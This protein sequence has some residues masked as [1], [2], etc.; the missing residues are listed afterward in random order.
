MTNASIVASVAT[1]RLA[2]PIPTAKLLTAWEFAK[3]LR[4]P[5]S[6]QAGCAALLEWAGQCKFESEVLDGL[7]PLVISGCTTQEANDFRRG[8]KR[9]SVAMDLMLATATGQ[10]VLVPSWQGCHSGPVPEFADLSAEEALLESGHALPG[11]FSSEFEQ[12]QEESGK[13]FLRQWAFEYQNLEQTRGFSD[14]NRFDYFAKEP[15]GASGMVVN[16]RSHAARSAFLRTL[17][18]AS[19]YWEMPLDLALDVASVALPGDPA[20]LRMVPGLAPPFAEQLYRAVDDTGVDADAISAVVV[21]I[22]CSDATQVPFHFSG[23]IH[24]AATLTVEVTV[25]AVPHVAERSAD[26]WIRWH[27]GLLGTAHLERNGVPALVISPVHGQPSDQDP[28]RVIPFLVPILPERVGYLHS[29]L[30]QRPPYLP[31]WVPG[32]NPI[33]AHPKEGGM[34][35]EIDGRP[36]GEMHYWMSN[37]SPLAPK[38]T[39][40]GTASC[41]HVHSSLAQHFETAIARR[42]GYACF[43]K[44]RRRSQTYGEWESTNHHCTLAPR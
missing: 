40:P 31:A 14:N 12:L 35:L 38:G 20:L 18:F 34:S 10:P 19:E 26:M 32:H 8:V 4:A 29:D 43:V 5:S 24:D 25:F 3:D 16:Q 41:I 22:L 11:I 44:I 42:I 37:W 36:V 23:C 33:L 6:R 21:D 28:S 2:L 9:P 1:A 30:I 7:V 13:P 15:Q 27:R 17:A 39:P